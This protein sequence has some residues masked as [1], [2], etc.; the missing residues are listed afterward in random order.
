MIVE[1]N[2]DHVTGVE[3][4][5]EHQ[6]KGYRHIAPVLPTVV[7]LNIEQNIKPSKVETG[8]SM[9]YT[10]G[11]TMAKRSSGLGS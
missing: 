1:F 9:T 11:E 4:V 2:M 3:H 10:Q 8:N 5:I 6:G 7:A